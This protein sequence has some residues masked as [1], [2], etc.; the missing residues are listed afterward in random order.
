MKAFAS[1]G[2]GEIDRSAF[3][4]LGENVIFETGALVFHPERIEIGNNVYVGHHCILKGYY[5]NSMLIGDNV[6]I[7]QQAFLHSA[8]GLTIGNNVG[9]GPAVK[10]LTSRH[11]EAGREVPI[12]AAPIEESPVIIEDDVDLGIGS[13]IMPGARIG[14]GA[15]IGAGAVVTRDIPPFAIA[16]GMPARVLRFRGE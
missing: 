5:R 2:T 15:Q 7:G 14:R 4:R 10:V 12:L 8:G 9:I 3:A 16:A 13:I 6:W 1:H 11:R